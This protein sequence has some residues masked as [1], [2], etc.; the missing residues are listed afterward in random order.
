M[1]VFVGRWVS[2]AL[3]VPREQGSPSRR[4]GWA[5][6]ALLCARRS[7]RGY[8]LQRSLRGVLGGG[9]RK[10]PPQLPPLPPPRKQGALG[11]LPPRVWE[12]HT[13]SRRGVA[14]SPLGLCY[15][16]GILPLRSQPHP[17]SSPGPGSRRIALVGKRGNYSQNSLD[18]KLFI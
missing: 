10:A 11:R 14:G 13:P 16:K 18:S 4:V 2:L 1:T 17:H 8:P 3:H 7:A 12:Q 9:D 6:L 15:P 5:Q